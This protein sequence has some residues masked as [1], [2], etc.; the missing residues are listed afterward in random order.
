MKLGFVHLHHWEKMAGFIFLN[1]KQ[2]RLLGSCMLNLDKL[3]II[4]A[5]NP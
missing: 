1:Y 2:G 3:I 4:E 5:F